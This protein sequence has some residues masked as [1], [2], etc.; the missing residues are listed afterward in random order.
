MTNELTD[1]R[2]YLGCFGNEK[3]L[4][5]TSISTNLLPHKDDFIYFDGEAYKVLYHMLD[6]DHNEYNIFIRLATEEDF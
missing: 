6:I 5:I 2:F 3:L 1:V 4:V